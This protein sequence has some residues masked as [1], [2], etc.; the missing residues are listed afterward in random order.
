MTGVRSCLDSFSLLVSTAP[1][2]AAPNRPLI[3]FQ[4][5]HPLRLK[6]SAWKTREAVTF[7]KIAKLKVPPTDM[8]Y[9]E[10]IDKNLAIQGGEGK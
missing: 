7:L 2:G 4:F 10:K 9:V 3:P 1:G 5:G 8:E 6:A